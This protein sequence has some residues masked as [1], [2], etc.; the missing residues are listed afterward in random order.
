MPESVRMTGTGTGG[1]PAG[2][3]A[4]RRRGGPAPARPGRTLLPR[5]GLGGRPMPPVHPELAAAVAAGEVASRAATVI[6]LALDRVRHSCLPEAA[7]AMEHALTRT[8]AENDADFLARV[9]PAAGPR[10]WTRTA[11]NP[12]RNCSASSRAPSSANPG[13]AC[14]TWKSSPPRTS[15]NT[16]I[17]VMNT[18]TNPRTGPGTGQGTATGPGDGSAAGRMR[19]CAADEPATARGGPRAAVPG[20]PL[21]AATAARRPGRRLQGG[22]RRRRAARRRRAPAP[23][24]G[25]HRLPGPA[26]P[27]RTTP[28]SRRLPTPPHGTGRRH[29]DRCCSPARSPP[30]PSARSPATPTSSRSSSAARARS[31]TSAAPPGS[32]R[33]TSARP[34]RPG[35]RAAPSRNAPS[36]H[37]GARPTTSPT[38]PAAEPPEPATEPCS[39]P[40]TTT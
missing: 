24:H 40:I 23:D 10:R 2:A 4:D 14:S 36:P 30:P 18:A 20:P 38:G 33:P 12:P 5:Q 29:R 1:V 21:P 28:P 16:S 35:T 15:S 9:S 6:T 13:T 11:P 22:P 37:P 26:H 32:S 8:A 27:A 34:S 25:H 17:T 31:W 7:A 39:A 3:A 19:P